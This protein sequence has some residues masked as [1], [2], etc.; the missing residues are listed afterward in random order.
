MKM[1]SRDSQTAFFLISR[2]FLFEPFPRNQKGILKDRMQ[3]ANERVR[4]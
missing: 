3:D 1:Q 4:K 2:K